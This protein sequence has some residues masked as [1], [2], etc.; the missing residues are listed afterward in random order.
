MQNIKCVVVG[1][2]YVWLCLEL[3]QVRGRVWLWL[4]CVQGGGKDVFADFL[5]D[6]LVPRR[7]YSYG[8]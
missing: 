6:Q 8:V 7:V 5:Y 1:D 4:K 2:G 3:F